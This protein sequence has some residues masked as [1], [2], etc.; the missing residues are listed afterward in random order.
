MEIIIK[1]Y[2]RV[3]TRS[4]GK[5]ELVYC[6]ED[7][8]SLPEKWTRSVP[9]IGAKLQYNVTVVEVAPPKLHATIAQ[10]IP[11]NVFV[12]TERDGE[13]NIVYVAVVLNSALA[14]GYFDLKPIGEGLFE[15]RWYERIM[16]VQNNVIGA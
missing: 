7:G 6:N 1:Q 5:K 2:A 14:Y 10:T 8:S 13:G 15:A 9:P 12:S 16:V 4:D 3:I 11:E